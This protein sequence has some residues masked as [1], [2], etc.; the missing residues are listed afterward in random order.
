V[1]ACVLVPI[2]WCSLKFHAIS[3]LFD[4]PFKLELLH[5]TRKLMDFDGLSNN[6]EIAWKFNLH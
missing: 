1:C 6:N 2:D 5:I 4:S 3:L